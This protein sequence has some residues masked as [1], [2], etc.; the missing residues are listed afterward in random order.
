MVLNETCRHCKREVRKLRTRGLCNICGYKPE[1]LK[2][3]P[4]RS[5]CIWCR[6][7]LDRAKLY[8]GYCEPC[9]DVP[10]VQQKIEAATLA[11]R[12][13]IAKARS[14]RTKDDFK[15]SALARENDETDEDLNS[16]I[17]EQTLT[18]PK[19]MS[20]DGKPKL[21]SVTT[22]SEIAAAK[23]RIVP[24]TVWGDD[25]VLTPLIES[26]KGG[27][28]RAIM[29]AD[30]WLQNEAK[31]LG[32]PIKARWIKRT[33]E[34][35]YLDHNGEIQQIRFL[36]KAKAFPVYPAKDPNAP[37]LSAEQIFYSRQRA[38]KA[39]RVKVTA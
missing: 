3:Y 25:D 15:R 34:I 27:F 29:E 18:M 16:L 1:I 20:N 5:F 7:P 26:G 35:Q 24:V 4:K 32:K 13:G 19:Y 21:L 38:R 28:T 12:A 31:Q 2:L 14:T 6:V 22:R 10:E 36:G 17:Q 8:R 37:K 11:A 9:Q 33:I 30:K 39:E 23:N